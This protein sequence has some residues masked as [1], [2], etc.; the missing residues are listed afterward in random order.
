MLGAPIAGREDRLTRPGRGQGMVSA[1]FSTFLAL[2]LLLH[3]ALF[4][5]AFLWDSHFSPP[6]P[7]EPI[8]VE[9]VEEPPQPE[10]QAEEQPKEEQKEAQ[11]EPPQ[12]PEEKQA[13]PEPE[14]QAELPPTVPLDLQAAT[15]APK[16]SQTDAE[17]TIGDKTPEAPLAVVRQEQPAPDPAPRPPEAPIP[18]P[19]P[20]KP[21]SEP[22][23]AEL[24]PPEAPPVEPLPLAPD[25]VP[26]QAQATPPE[27]AEPE[28]PE[29]QE[30][31]ETPD[32]KRFAF[33]APLPKMEFESGG[34]QSRAPAGGA[35]ASYTSTL[36]GMIVPLVRVPMGL[37]PSARRRPLR[38]EFVVDGRGRLVGL[39]LSRSSGVPSLDVAALAAVRQAAPYPPTP[40]GQALGLVLDYSPQ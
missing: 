27:K 39:T 5:A 35:E 1:R 15:D 16:S 6:P 29:P 30:K 22:V 9:L 33:F 31:A 26:E 25:G 4:G 11:K 17:L 3:A 21:A 13:E 32:A 2:G 7:P 37:P 14:K 8:A 19:E 38:I 20:A 28:K 10:P 40:H 34:K 36:Y 24:A 12:T 18:T 23:K